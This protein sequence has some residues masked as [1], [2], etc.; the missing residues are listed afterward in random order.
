MVRLG[1]PLGNDDLDE[2]IEALKKKEQEYI[3]EGEARLKQDKTD[4]EQVIEQEVDDELD[5]ER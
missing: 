3:E 1:P 4:R 2:K 5:R